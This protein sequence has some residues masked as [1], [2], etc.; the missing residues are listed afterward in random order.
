MNLQALGRRYARFATGVAVRNPHLW[1]LV[2]PLMRFQFDRLAGRWDTMRFDGAFAP[3]EAALERVEAPARALDVGTGTGDGAFLIA[4]RFPGAE[5]VGADLAEA[6][7][8]RARE[9]TPEDLRGRVRFDRADASDLPYEDSAFDL[10]ALGNMIPFFDE[11][12]RVLRPGGAVLAAFSAGPETPI[13]V[14]PD[15]LRAEF[16][17]RGFTDFAEIS[18]GRGTAFLA[19]KGD[20]A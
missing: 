11:L 10:V 1:R 13:Y 6:M 5:V 4:R 2:R 15:R 19:R 14:P 9:K 7:V 18:A 12:A 16:S 8:E 17:S 3:F 20:Q